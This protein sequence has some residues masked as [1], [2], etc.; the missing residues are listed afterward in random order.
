MALEILNKSKDA[1]QKQ[2]WKERAWPTQPREHRSKQALLGE[3]LQHE[4]HIVQN[5]QWSFSIFL[6]LKI[7]FQILNRFFPLFFNSSL[8]I[9]HY[10]N[11]H[12]NCV[13]NM[14]PYSW[15]FGTTDFGS[16]HIKIKFKIKGNLSSFFFPLSFKSYN[17]KANISNFSQSHVLLPHII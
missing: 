3:D 4:S 7:F 11:G 12:A 2:G 6:F 13:S 1:K 10:C 14:L 9:P 8:T 16:P 17:Y 5:S 15:C